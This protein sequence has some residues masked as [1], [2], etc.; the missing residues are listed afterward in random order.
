MMLYKGRKFEL[1][2]SIGVGGRGNVP[3]FKLAAETDGEVAA[4]R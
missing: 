3:N 1:T 4:R 2:G